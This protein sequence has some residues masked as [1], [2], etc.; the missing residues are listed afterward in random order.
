[1]VL[2]FKIKGVKF[3]ITLGG[4]FENGG[5]FPYNLQNGFMRK[6]MNN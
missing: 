6:K 5:P 2:Q 1:M 4:R 3:V